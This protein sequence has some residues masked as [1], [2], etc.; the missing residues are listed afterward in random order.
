MESEVAKLTID[1]VDIRL[2][3]CSRHSNGR[4]RSTSRTASGASV[5]SFSTHYRLAHR[6]PSPTRSFGR[7]RVSETTG[8]AACD[9]SIRALESEQIHTPFRRTD[10]DYVVVWEEELGG[11][12]EASAEQSTRNERFRARFETGLAREGLEFEQV[13]PPCPPLL[14]A[15]NRQAHSFFSRAT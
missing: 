4:G 12:E 11:E 5:R 9:C 8:G 1:N 7:V 10:A 15:Y 3:S 13:R 2:R 6:S 14:R